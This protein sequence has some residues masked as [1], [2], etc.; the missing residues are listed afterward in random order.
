MAAGAAAAAAGRLVGREAA[1]KKVGQVASDVA[2]VRQARPNAPRVRVR[3]QRGG[4]RATI[5]TMTI[6]VGAG[7][8]RNIVVEGKNLPDRKFW[9][10]MAILGFILSLVTEIE[11][12][13]G[14][15]LAYLVLVAAMISQTEDIITEL[16]RQ[17]DRLARSSTPDD[18]DPMFTQNTPPRNL[19]LA[20][21]I[22]IPTVVPTSNPRSTRRAP[23]PRARYT[24][25][26]SPRTV[27]A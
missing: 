22:S 26:S 13:V 27:T 12:R 9:F 14:R 1:G 17:E 21:N 16:N 23:R 24:D 10:N 4:Q 11:P 25:P 2:T 18:L 3:E 20:A 8:L 7:V 15:P 5:M 6:V 19:Q